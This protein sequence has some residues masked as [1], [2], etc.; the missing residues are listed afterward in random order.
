MKCVHLIVL[1][2]VQGVFFRYHTRS[3]AIE[4]GLK[5]YAKNLPDGNVEVA[6][7]GDE[8]KLNEL[9][10]FIRKGPGNAKV[11]DIKINHKDIENFKS[12]EIR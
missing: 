7:E 8:S 9:V 3:K 10:D 11:T 4:L 6:A 5:G 2:R 1:G 12:F